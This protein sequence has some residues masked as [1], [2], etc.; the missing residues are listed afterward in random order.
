MRD[1]AITRREF[2][3]GIL[4]GAQGFNVQIIGRLISSRRYPGT[5]QFGQMH[6][7]ALA[8][9]LILDGLTIVPLKLKTTVSAAV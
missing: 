9:G 1:S 7:I 3:Q 6:T 2:Q 4:Q 5:K 8:A